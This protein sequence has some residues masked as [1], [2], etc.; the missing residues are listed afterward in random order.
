ML[1]GEQSL[2]EAIVAPDG[3][4]VNRVF[5]WLCEQSDLLLYLNFELTLKHVQILW[6]SQQLGL[7]TCPTC[8]GQCLIRKGWRP[9]IVVTSRGRLPF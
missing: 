2:P 4:T 7:L 9:R 8:N 6:F 3:Q 1:P 5:D